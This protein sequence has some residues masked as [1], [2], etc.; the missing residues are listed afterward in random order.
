MYI[1]SDINRLLIMI[2]WSIGSIAQWFSIIVSS[3]DAITRCFIKIE[4]L[5]RALIVNYIKTEQQ[6]HVT[7]H[8]LTV[9]SFNEML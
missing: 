4:L 1:N 5:V 9:S 8:L 2:V 7:E 3:I 6:V